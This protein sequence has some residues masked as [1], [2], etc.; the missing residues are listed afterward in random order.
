MNNCCDKCKKGS[1]ILRCLDDMCICHMNNE[2]EWEEEFEDKFRD[3]YVGGKDLSEMMTF[4]ES[5]RQ[6][7]Y[8][9]GVRF[10][11][12]GRQMF[13]AGRQ[14]MVEEILAELPKK[15]EIIHYANEEGVD[16]LVK[17]S[18]RFINLGSNE[19]LSAIR[20]LIEKKKL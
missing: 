13:E 9:E 11:N 6:K 10:A 5:L 3:A 4:I 2:Y 18:H 17:Q 15:R 8:E 19:C 20:D 14:A 12:S 16:G 1:V 7:A